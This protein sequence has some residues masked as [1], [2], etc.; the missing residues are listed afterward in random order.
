MDGKSSSGGYI[1]NDSCNLKIPVPIGVNGGCVLR[2]PIA[3]PERGGY[4]IKI[5]ALSTEPGNARLT[6]VRCIFKN[7]YEKFMRNIDQNQSQL[8]NTTTNL[9]HFRETT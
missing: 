3:E 6:D 4:T 2:S 1:N 5:A 7:L 8:I 9:K